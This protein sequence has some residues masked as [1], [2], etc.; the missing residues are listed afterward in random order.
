M[1]AQGRPDTLVQRAARL[2]VAK[3]VWRVGLLLAVFQLPVFPWCGQVSSPPQGLAKLPPDDAA[4]FAA[5]Q[6]QKKLRRSFAALR[7]T[8]I[9][10]AD[11]GLSFT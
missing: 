8:K 3:V 2:S 11:S 5:G 4:H 6:N 1:M 9:A 10:Q 7:M